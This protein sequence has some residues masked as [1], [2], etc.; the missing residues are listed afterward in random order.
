MPTINTTFIGMVANDQICK[1]LTE[2]LKN[3]FGELLKRAAEVKATFRV[4]GKRKY[5]TVTIMVY[6]P[7]VLIRVEE[8][9][10]DM[11]S[12][13]DLAL[14]KLGIRLKRYHDKLREWRGEKLWN[15]VE[16]EEEAEQEMSS[17]PS[18][19]PRVRRNKSFRKGEK[20]DIGEAIEYLELLGAPCYLFRN[21]ESGKWSV[22]YPISEG[23]YG[24]I[25]AP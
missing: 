2:K 8:S 17:Y 23:E 5:S 19:I 11:R 21:K 12:L 4:H 15:I 16:L 25:E 10:P 22:V 18:Y 20:I 14:D 7:Q 6:M 24:L 13:I 9:G 1:H 3:R